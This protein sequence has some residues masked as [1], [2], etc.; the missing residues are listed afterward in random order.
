MTNRTTLGRIWAESGQRVDPDEDGIQ[1]YSQGWL[2]E[3]PSYE[4]LNFLQWRVDIALTALAERGIPEWGN[5]I[6][7]LRGALAWDNSDNTVYRAKVNSPSRGLAPSAN[8][9]QWEPSAIQVTTTQWIAANNKIDTHIARVDNPHN[10]TAEQVN[11]Y[12][13]SVIDNKIGAVNTTITNHINNT[14]NPHNTTAAQAGAVPITGGT[15]TGAVTFTAEETKINPSAG[16]QAV[17][18]NATMAGIRVGTTRFGIRKGDGR[19]V[20]TQGAVTDLM[21]NEEEY[22]ALRRTIEKDYTPP[23]EDLTMDLLT[24]VNIRIGYGFSNFTRPTAQ[25]YTNKAGAVVSAPVDSPRFTLAGLMLEGSKTEK[26]EIDAAYNWAGFPAAT[27]FFEGSVD[28]AQGIASIYKDNSGRSDEILV[29]AN[30][31]VLLRVRDS[32]AAVREFKAGT[33]ATKQIFKFAMSWDPAGNFKTY[34]DGVPGQGSIISFAPTT[35][36]TTIKMG[37]R[38]TGLLFCRKFQ[39]WA[40]TLTPEIIST[41]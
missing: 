28:L 16:D 15:Y 4:V 14:S 29:A 5:D 3:I 2:A 38:T 34:L 40:V 23:V 33:V 20:R 19:L 8:P 18:G 17:F 31:D 11:T 41:L 22:V 26:L 37:D 30:G 1:K 6:G 32:T 9:S 25:N 35:G 10:V 12:I 27:L 24:D 39:T 36:Y 13:K 7:Y 21:M